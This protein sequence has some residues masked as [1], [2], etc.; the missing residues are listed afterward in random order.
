MKNNVVSLIK[1]LKSATDE[2]RLSWM[3][4]SDPEGYSCSIADISIFLKKMNPSQ[5]R[6]HVEYHL[7]IM[8]SFGE[9]LERFEVNPLDNEV[10][11]DIYT[12]ISILF[13]IAKRKSRGQGDL[14]D[15]LL[16]KF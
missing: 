13:N 16:T 1:K 12:D 5:N 6:L 8:N 4:T 14:I 7:F 2:N 9:I 15:E 11:N 3:S 10:K